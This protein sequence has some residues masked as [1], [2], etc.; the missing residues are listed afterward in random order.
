M[1]VRTGLDMLITDDFAPIAGKRVGLLTN[2]AAI[3]AQLK[4][5]LSSF[6]EGERAGRFVLAALFAPEHGIDAVISAGEGVDTV[7]QNGVIV[8][9][10]YG[11]TVMPTPAMLAPLDVIVCDLQDVGARFYTYIWSISHM[12]EAAVTASKPVILLDRPNPI[13]G[14]IVE[15]APLDPALASFV[16]RYNIPVRHG[17]TLGEL[18]TLIND[19]FLPARADL[20]V[21]ACDGWRRSMLWHDTGRPFAPPSPNIPNWH[22]TL[23]YPGSCLIE[24]TTLSEGR[25][26]ALPFHIVGAPFIDANRLA[27]ALNALNAHGVRFRPHT[28]QPQASKYAG[29]LCQGVQAHI[30]DPAFYRPV[31]TWVQVIKTIHDLYPDDFA[32]LPPAEGQP[33]HIDRLIGSSAVREQIA[34]GKP[35]DD[36]FTAWESAA[37]DFEGMRWSYLLYM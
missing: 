37:H 5:A 1:L 11:K 28:F 17:L 9:S 20:T 3:D 4:S 36:L 15:H 33:Y 34:A 14:Q 25:G 24:G 8:H 35:L 18:A 31:K 23:H 21:I 22:T 13:G 27:D 32:W 12:L 19:H 16:G 7:E 10:L 6:R 2:P 30:T 29:V 26:T